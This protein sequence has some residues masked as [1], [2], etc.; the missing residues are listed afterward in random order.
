VVDALRPLCASHERGERK[1]WRGG[2]VLS[3]E[4]VVASVDDAAAS[5]EVAE[6]GAS[7]ENRLL[8]VC[9]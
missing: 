9:R 1:A 4:A 2:E 3:A 8:L 6:A 5:L 7:S